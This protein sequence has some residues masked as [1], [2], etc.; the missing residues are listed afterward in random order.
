[1]KNKITTILERD[2]K[3]DLDGLT[4]PEAIQFLRNM[5]E[6]FGEGV[7]LDVDSEDYSCDIR[8]IHIRDETDEEAK[9]REE[10]ALAEFM[11]KQDPEYLADL[12][13]YKHLK[14]KLGLS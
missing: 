4:I 7:L 3:W 14:Q 10:E 13:T 5:A 6:C 8:L 1:M 2:I 9:Q 12:A 11:S